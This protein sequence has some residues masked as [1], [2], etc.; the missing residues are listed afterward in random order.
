MKLHQKQ[1]LFIVGLIS[2]LLAYFGFGQKINKPEE[3]INRVLTIFEP[4]PTPLPADYALIT[5]VIDGDT[6][7]LENGQH[8][9]Y[10]GINTPEIDYE[11]GRDDCYAQEARQ[12]NQAL[13]E[14]KIVR[15]E[16]D[17]SETDQYGR[18]LRY[19]YVGDI[20]VNA[21]LVQ[22]GFAQV[23][24]FPPD[25][26]NQEIFVEAQNRARAASSGFWGKDCLVD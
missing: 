19:A 16:K 13:V 2:L 9:R 7:E 22:E 24:T 1:R 5:R 3:L 21:V 6:I 17:V 26:K 12:K 18:L 23:S 11:N 15:L 14:G 4:S 10:I 20:F 8:V 25:V